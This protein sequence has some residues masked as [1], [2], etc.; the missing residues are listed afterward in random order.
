MGHECDIF[1]S[2]DGGGENVERIHKNAFKQSI[3]IPR[4]FSR[5]LLKRGMGP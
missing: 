5:I 2:G 3:D 4:H 1:E